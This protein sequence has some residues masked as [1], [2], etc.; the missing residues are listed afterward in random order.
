MAMQAS[1]LSTLITVWNKLYVY[2]KHKLLTMDYYRYLEGILS[3]K[4][5]EKI[6]INLFIGIYISTF[7]E[8]RMRA[9]HGMWWWNRPT[10]SSWP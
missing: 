3:F 6:T 5:L 7:N 10:N 1:N 8:L 2:I 4:H 9:V